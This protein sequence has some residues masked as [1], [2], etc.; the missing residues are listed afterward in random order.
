M[1]ER[2]EMHESAFFDWKNMGETLGKADLQRYFP[3]EKGWKIVEVGGESVDAR[4]TVFGTAIRCIDR[5]FGFTP[6]GYKPETVP[7]SPA[8]LGAVDGVV[9]FLEGTPEERMEQA[10]RRTESIGFKS[11]YHGDYARGD[12]G[13][14]YRRA[15]MEGRFE[16]LPPITKEEHRVLTTKIGLHYVQLDRPA[17]RN[18]PEGFVLNEFVYETV[19]PGGGRFYPI[20]I[21]F[22][23][24]VGI[25]DE[26]SLP[27]IAKCG[28]LLLPQNN[29]TLF[30]VRG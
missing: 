5:D 9:S 16:G 12:D 4:R 27:V 22:A 24:M 29:K 26:K 8:W 3:A 14:A 1:K 18:D 30:I 6:N 20:D 2:P 21:W 13:C 15:L 11:A 7:P 25:T 10:V 19:L 28:E 17:V 23:R